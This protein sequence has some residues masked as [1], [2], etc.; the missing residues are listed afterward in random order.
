M[1]SKIKRNVNLPIY[2]D[3]EHQPNKRPKSR[4]PIW[5]VE[6]NYNDLQVE[7]KKILWLESEVR[8]SSLVEDPTVR[9]PGFNLPRASWT[10]LNRMKTE[11][12]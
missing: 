12:G 1:I 4:C 7:W 3:I 11:Q 2:N 8:N 9:I 5:K 6:T 10:T